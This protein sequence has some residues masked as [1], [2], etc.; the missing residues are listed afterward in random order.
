[1]RALVCQTRVPEID[2]DRG[3]QRVDQM[4]G[5]LQKAGWS[6]TFLANNTD[7][8]ERHAKRLRQQGVATFTG[9]DQAEDVIAA[10]D[11][12]LALLAFWQPASQVMQRLRAVSPRTKVIVD[13]IDLHFLR[14]AR[15]MFGAAGGLDARFGER[16]VGELNTYCA[17]DAVLTVST[18]EAELLEDFLGPGRVHELPL[19]EALQRSPLPFK[20]RRGILFVGNFR[21][22]PNGEAVEYLCRDVL[23]SLDPRLLA[24]HP[25]L[26]VGSRLDDRVRAYGRGLPGVKMVGWVP[27][28]V[29]YVQQA[30]VSAV[31]LLHG[32][33][34]KGKLVEALMGGTPAVST[35]IGVEGIGLE[36]GQGALIADSARGFANG[37]TQMLTDGDAWQRVVD[38]GQ[39][40]LQARYAPEE[41]QRRFVEIVDRVLH[42]PPHPIPDGVEAIR[43]REA[44][45]RATIDG[46]EAALAAV[47]EPGSI[48]LVV[49]RGDD[50]LV[51]PPDRVG[52]HFPRATDGRWAGYHPA[53]SE[54]AIAHLQGLHDQGARYLALPSTAYW[55]LHHY[56]ELT[57]YLEAHA[58]RVHADEYVIVFDL[59]VPPG[60]ESGPD[61]GFDPGVPRT[62]RSAPDA[63]PRHGRERV[64]VLGTYDG[65]N[66]G[67]PRAAVEALAA[68]QRYAVTQR[69]SSDARPA[70]TADDD[71]DWV[72]YVDPP[73]IFDDG[74]LD[75]F[76]EAASGLLPLGVERVQPAHASGPDAAPPVTERLGG[77]FAH[78]LAGPTPLPVLATRR[79][80][81]PGGP[82]AIID[83]VTIE[84][85]APLEGTA[86][87]D[88]L[89]V[90]AAGPRRAV[91][92]N[93]GVAWPRISVLLATHDRH[94]LLT[95][96]LEGF[97]NQTLRDFEVVVVDDGSP[98]AETEALFDRFASRLTLRWVRIEHSGRSAAKNLALLLARADLVLWFD[99]DDIPD[100]D[101]LEQHVRAHELH[102]GEATA[103]LGHT[104]WAEELELTPLMH[105]LTDIDRLLF[106]YPS[107]TAGQRLDWRGFWEGR[108]SSKR[109]LHVN[110][111]LHDQR[112]A[113]SIDVEMA[114]RLARQG[115]EVVYL[116]DARSSMA[117]PVSLEAFCRRSEAKGRAQ[118]LIAE[119][120]D[121]DVLRAYTHVDGAAKLWAEA[122]PQLQATV[123]RAQE[124]ELAA[125]IDDS[126]LPEL[127]RCYRAVFGAYNAKGIVAA[128]DPVPL[129]NGSRSAGRPEQP[130]LTVTMPVWSRSD[131]LA[132]MARD[133]LQRVL[134]VATMP[135]EIV[136]VD[137]G[138]THTC[139]MPGRLHRFE[140]N[141]GVA[142]GWNT[143]I[144]LAT[145]PVVAVLNSDCRVEPGWD[146]ALY[147]AVTTG[148]RIAFPYTDHGDG[149]GYRQPDQAGTAGWCFM[150][151]KQLFEEVGTF[152]ELFNPAYG[153]DTDYWHRAWEMGIELSPVPA[154]RV[155][156]ERRSSTTANDR[157]EWLLT[158]HRYLYGWKHGVEPLRAPPYYNR[159]V[160]EY[161]ARGAALEQV[162]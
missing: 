4:I 49:S 73:A 3:S 75:D 113:Y 54:T 70:P 115:L 93:Q 141:R 83:S 31:P 125:S 23:P 10:G 82:V 159:E 135:T 111:G 119:L 95:T 39:E 98:T 41:V 45:Y 21:H 153:E 142:T 17:A 88:V 90:F 68:S 51:E 92:R 24:D 134:D 53:D 144:Q 86:P 47:T 61:A 26:V 52:W 67:P 157:V 137:N 11:F 65:A 104:R 162:S 74:F 85:A 155:F 22:L 154:A 132:E 2:R 116:P 84:L 27:S 138:S 13:S 25:L 58:K 151:T 63:G 148:R 62:N 5:W 78:E 123:A 160:I 81:K 12:D 103:I 38:S 156:H 66:A 35:S 43:G 114:W 33:G 96:C 131:A 105:Y 130:M 150:L 158:G 9:I 140:H 89:D 46:V 102:P 149:E 117:R 56:A 97:C 91:R 161:A 146:E 127:H 64:L 1:M 101:L 60:D 7:G 36:D 72:L 124:L 143:G 18:K 139:A 118:A 30:R 37:L 110:H 136:V 42:Q 6:V 120:H 80:A 34:V 71:P 15:Q 122:A 76:L 128:D 40:L 145:A 109:A 106:A 147:E 112:L 29:P 16:L 57:E 55:W 48:V 129:T 44:S 126:V 107:L 59:G 8:D 133:T 94:E 50:R 20:D 32:A 14:E 121:D 108:I 19:A 87:S 99:D 79:D 77:I 69:W 28:I 152:D 100:P